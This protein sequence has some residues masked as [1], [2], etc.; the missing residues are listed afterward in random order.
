MHSEDSLH[1]VKLIYKIWASDRVV[2]P[3]IVKSNERAVVL[4]R[5][6]SVN[7]DAVLIQQHPFVNRVEHILQTATEVRVLG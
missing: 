7:L 6:N 2:V 3:N 4:A 1:F 5:S